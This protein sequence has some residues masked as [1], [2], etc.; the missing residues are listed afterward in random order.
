MKDFVSLLIGVAAFCAAYLILGAL[1]EHGSRMN[2]APSGLEHGS[3]LHF[4][5]ALMVAVWAKRRAVSRSRL[6]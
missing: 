1:I 3:A 4:G 5:V 2:V 6:T